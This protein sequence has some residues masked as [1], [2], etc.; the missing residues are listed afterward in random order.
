MIDYFEA[1]LQFPKIKNF[2]KWF[3]RHIKILK[4]QIATFLEIEKK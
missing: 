2:K 4:N 3:N 1:F